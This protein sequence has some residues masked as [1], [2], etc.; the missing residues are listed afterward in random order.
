[1]RALRGGL[2]VVQAFEAPLRRVQEHGECRF[3]VRAIVGG[4]ERPRRRVR[5]A[6]RRAARAGGPARA[7]EPRRVSVGVR[8]V[9]QQ[10]AARLQDSRDLGKELLGLRDVL[11]HH[12]CRGE[13]E[14]PGLETAGARISPRTRCRRPRCFAE[15]SPSASM[16]TMTQR[17]RAAAAAVWID[18]W[19]Q[20]VVS[21]AQIEPV[22]RA[23]NLRPRSAEHTR[24]ASSRDPEPNR[25]TSRQYARSAQPR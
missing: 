20:E 10:T 22:R 24:D 3:G 18:K 12:V 19:R 8:R 7:G 25:V 4:I 23:R 17:D 21:A 11:D 16:P 5:A 9:E 15:R 1:M 14:R 2:D 13:V 6:S